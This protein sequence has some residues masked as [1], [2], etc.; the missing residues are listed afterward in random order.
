MKRALTCLYKHVL[1][2]SKSLEE[3]CGVQL[4]VLD[5]KVER[6]K[7][8]LVL[9]VN[10][11]DGSDLEDVLHDLHVAIPRSNVNRE[12]ALV[13]SFIL[14]EAILLLDHEA[15]NDL[16]A[17]EARAEVENVPAL[18]VDFVDFVV[19]VPRNELCH[20]LEAKD[21]AQGQ[22]KEA[23]IIDFF[24]DLCAKQTA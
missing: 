18:F 12:V 11:L 16:Q 24:V 15:I 13:V 10:L 5:C 2:A 20:D 9:H 14:D 17:V 1:V 19:L 6:S 21:D 7:T 3:L 23:L 8:L 22:R 4:P